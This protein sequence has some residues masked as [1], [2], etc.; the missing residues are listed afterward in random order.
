MTLK[1]TLSQTP[2]GMI[3]TE[4]ATIK[5]ELCLRGIYP[6]TVAGNKRCECEEYNN[7]I[8]SLRSYPTFGFSEDQIGEVVEGVIEQR[9]TKPKDGV[10]GIARVPYYV[11]IPAP[12]CNPG[13]SEDTIMKVCYVCGSDYEAMLCDVDGCNEEQSGGGMYWKE[14][15]YWSIC[16][17]H[18]DAGRKGESQPKMRASAIAK[19]SRRDKVTGIM[20]PLPATGTQGEYV[21]DLQDQVRKHILDDKLFD[22]HEALS[23]NEMEYLE[24]LLLTFCPIFQPGSIGY[25]KQ[26]AQQT[27]T[28]G[29][30]EIIKILK[31]IRE[32]FNWIWDNMGKEHTSD[33]FNIPANG[34][35]ALD[36]L[37]ASFP[38]PSPVVDIKKLVGEYYDK[39]TKGWYPDYWPDYK[40]VESSFEAGYA[41]ALSSPSSPQ[42]EAVGF[43]E[44]ILSGNADKQLDYWLSKG[45]RKPYTSAELYTI[46]QSNKKQ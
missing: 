20:Q 43:A 3:L 32:A 24:Q 46:Y 4:L 27:G 37:I 10:L 11:A 22:W 18:M 8:K 29:E 39:V 13:E 33:H 2:Q 1:G 12:T 23:G 28:Q 9:G 44:W 40:V 26:H 38:Q 35:Q 5:K 25:A 41:A 19:E 15:G 16:S 6:C 7:H 30:G 21:D 34:I 36:N 31:E 17:K 42:A 45:A 14:T